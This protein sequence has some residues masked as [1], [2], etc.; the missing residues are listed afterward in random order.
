MTDSSTG[1]Y[2][3][4]QNVS[5]TDQ[6]VTD[7]MQGAM[8]AIVGLPGNMVRP[9]WQVLPPRQPDVGTDWVALGITSRAPIDYPVIVDNKG[10]D[11]PSTLVRWSTI[12]LLASFYGP[13]A[14]GNAETL[15]DGL[16]ITQ[17]MDALATDDVKLL[18]AGELTTVP[19]MLQNQWYNRVDIP[20]RFSVSTAR[21][22]NILG[23][24]SAEVSIASSAPTTNDSVIA[25]NVWAVTA[26][27]YGVGR[28]SF[29]ATAILQA[30][31]TL[32]GTG[33][34]RA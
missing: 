33:A 17:N 23:I 11:G 14:Q 13:N 25:Q 9:R 1:G 24:T 3:Q 20:V 18:D 32:A 15:R 2:L 8:V 7:A 26:R 21:D 22:Y 10:K 31:A 27:L 12:T 29:N 28:T 19:E 30:T 34:V 5:L 6:Q 16:Y 4:Q